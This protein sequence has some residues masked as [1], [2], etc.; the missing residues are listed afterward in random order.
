[1]WKD[2]AVYRED[3]QRIVA[4]RNIPW[5]ELDGK[6]VL[7]TGATGLIGSTLVNALLYY[8]EKTASPPRVLAFV[9]N[10]EKARCLYREQLA[11]HSL[12]LSFVVGDICAPAAV[13]GPVDYIIHAAS[14]TASRSFVERPVEII[15]TAIDGTKNMLELARE[16]QVKAF[17][18]LSSMEAYGSPT[19][20][21]ILTEDAPACFNSMAVRSCYPESKRMCEMLTAA[22]ASEYR[23]PGRV[24][25]L[26]QT[27][28]PGIAPDDVRVFAAFARKA[29]AGEDIELATRGDSK[30]MY[31]YTAD[32]ARAILTILLMGEPGCCYNAANPDTYCSIYEMAQMVSRQ[33]SDGQ[34]KILFSSDRSAAEKYPPGHRLKLDVTKLTALGWR[35]ST[36]LEEMYSRMIAGMQAEKNRV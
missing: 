30:R 12:Y 27:F 32:A 10:E 15:R 29:L 28:G 20:E 35:P 11:A 23:V 8:G 18:Y 4:D 26:A 31:L 6:T 24:V 16:K 7:V 33:F 13:P 25:R 34:T 19:E 21:K 9:R 5:Q 2:N 1:M 17:L 22:Y 14:E 36:G 3:L